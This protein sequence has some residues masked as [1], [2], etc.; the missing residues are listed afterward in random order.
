MTWTP[1][2]GSPPTME[3]TDEIFERAEELCLLA[4]EDESY[5]PLYREAMKKAQSLE[6]SGWKRR[7]GMSQEQKVLNHIKTTGSITVREAMI[8]YHI[9]SLTK[10]ISNLRAEGHNI[11]SNKKRHAVTGADYVRYTLATA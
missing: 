6:H 7:N 4:V 8:E 3:N 10:R 2:T 5:I 11:I 9:Q 1:H